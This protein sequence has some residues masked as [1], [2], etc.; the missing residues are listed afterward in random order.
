MQPVLSRL[1]ITD[2]ITLTPEG[3]TAAEQIR[4]IKSMLRRG[5]WLFVMHYHSPSL[6]PGHTPYV[7]SAKDADRFVQR[8]R[9]VC[10]FSSRKSEEC[11]DIH[12][13]YS[14]SRKAGYV[15]LF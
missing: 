2:T 12:P 7:R 15:A 5:N 4:L 14:T 3:V 1:R 9:E 11:P 6:S 8:I 13:I 10:R